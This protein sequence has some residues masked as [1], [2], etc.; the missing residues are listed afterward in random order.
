MLLP[1]CV[2]IKSAALKHKKTS[3]GVKNSWEIKQ[4]VKAELDPIKRLNCIVQSEPRL[5]L[6]KVNCQ[7]VR[8]VSGYRRRFS[9]SV[10]FSSWGEKKRL[11]VSTVNQKATQ[12]QQQQHGGWVNTVNTHTALHLTL[13]GSDSLSSPLLPYTSLCSF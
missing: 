3:E 8:P 11:K 5:Y 1:V 2:Q 12:Q 4:E 13:S 9:V 10:C 7:R 6:Q